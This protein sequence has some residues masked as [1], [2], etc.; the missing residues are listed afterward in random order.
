MG[1]VPMLLASCA[2]EPIDCNYS[3]TDL[4]GKI[5]VVIESDKPSTEV[6]YW[7]G[8]KK[9]CQDVVKHYYSCITIS[10]TDRVMWFEVNDCMKKI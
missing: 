8:S 4:G 3:L 10:R 7:Y 9:I 5:Q 2:K 1:L 6:C